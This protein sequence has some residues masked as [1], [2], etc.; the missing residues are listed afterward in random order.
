MPSLNVYCIAW[1]WKVIDRKF[2][3]VVWISDLNS[4]SHSP[5]PSLNKLHHLRSS[6]F[7]ICRTRKTNPNLHWCYEHWFIAVFRGDQSTDKRW[8]KNAK[9]FY[10]TT[11]KMGILPRSALAKMKA[12]MPTP[13]PLGPGNWMA[14]GY[15]AGFVNSDQGRN[16]I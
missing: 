5:K 16:N 2:K 10:Y 13:D 6:L 7:P 8:K 12:P 11:M 3:A 15:L 9:Y 14:F 1:S 4:L